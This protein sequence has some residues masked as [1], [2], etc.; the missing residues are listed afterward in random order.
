M[1]IVTT[2]VCK[3]A[4][5]MAS[6]SRTTNQD[7]SIRDDI[8]KVEIV[9]FSNG[10]KVLVGQSGHADLGARAVQNIATIAQDRDL[11]SYWDAVDVVEKSV[12]QIKQIMRE[13]FQGST[14]EFQKHV[15]DHD[16]HLMVAHYHEQ[17]KQVKPLVFT[18]Q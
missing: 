4:I 11:N 17:S 6:D 9:T 12:S 16:F 8:K 10:P 14:Q 3:E 15:E 13:Q 18:L 7:G 2:I 1:T 5:L